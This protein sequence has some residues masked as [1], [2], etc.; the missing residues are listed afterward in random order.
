LFHAGF[1][2]FSGGY[3]G[4]DVFFVISGFLITTIIID[5][6]ERDD[7]S[8][9]RFYERRARRILPALFVV[10]M[11]CLPFA[12][13][14]MLPTQLEA[15][16]RSL[17][18]LAFFGSNILFAFEHSYFS[19]SAELKPL[20]H[21][22]S[23]AV[24]EQYYL[25]F[26]LFIFIAW[27][28]GRHRVFWALV[29]IAVLSFLL[30]EW[31]SGTRPN[32][33]FYVAP[34]RAWELL[35]GS[36]CAFLTFRRTRP[37]SDVLSAVGFTLIVVSVFAYDETVLSPSVYTLAPVIGAAL[38]I[39]FAVE[40]TWVARLLST[41]VFVG[42]GLIS[43]S[44]YLWHQPLFAFARLRSLNELGHGWMAALVVAAL[45]L[46]W[47]TW[48]Y[49]EQPFRRPASPA[50]ANRRIVFAASGAVVAVFAAVG[51]AVHFNEGFEH[52]LTGELLRVAA[53]QSDKP[54]RACYHD[55]G[56]EMPD[57]P[58]SGC[59]SAN[60]YGEIDVIMLG[61]SH[62]VSLSEQVSQSLKSNGIGSYRASY[63]G[64]MPFVGF[65]RFGKG[66]VYECDEFYRGAYQYAT[67]HKVD[68]VVLT[69][70]YQLFLNGDRF[71]NGE[72]GKETGEPAWIDLTSHAT[73]DLNDKA[74]RTRV[75][76]AM[77][78]NI[79]ALA[80]EFKVVLVYPVPEAGWDVPVYGFKKAYFGDGA[81]ELTTSYSAYKA[82][83]QDI[84]ALFDKIIDDL[85]NVYGARVQ[86]I[87]CS[88]TN[89][90]CVNADSN[91]VY[92]HDDDH[93]STVGAR[94]V[95]PVVLEAIEKALNRP[96]IDN[97]AHKKPVEDVSH[98]VSQHF[99]G[100]DDLQK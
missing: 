48:R 38:V 33:N 24:E 31:A 28:L 46:A 50:Y 70:R 8:I 94:L 15:F 86:E 83:V 25:L 66:G 26:P 95:G 53:A 42:V 13:M 99:F 56:D 21:T 47:M 51:L 87:L 67:E 84:N 64:C 92:Y 45:M 80:Q 4:V 40:G 58:V 18:A 81:V 57:H 10:V 19:E 62:S 36:I 88:D 14:W 59:L 54:Q 98:L 23:L 73:S 5:E 9:T 49:V 6:I 82:R 27:R 2:A 12:Y 11:A 74:R 76:R 69:S 79:R 29:T 16:A 17:A 20:L 55:H 41:R 32:I 61:D 44:A 60:D 43:Y 65:R 91:G 100:A 96:A 93:L 71:D 7:F 97:L 3:I 77:E 35:V 39:L 1:A 78:E 72:G 30:S 37:L 85:P 22:W 75:L 90:R 63:L 52:R 68:V 34:T 89:G